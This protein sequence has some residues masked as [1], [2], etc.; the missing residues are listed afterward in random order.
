[1]PPTGRK[2]IDEPSGLEYNI[3]VARPLGIVVAQDCFF[4]R[5]TALT[6]SD[7]L[8]HKAA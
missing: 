3:D 1:M 5:G 2:N 7:R 6:G 4:E 8:C